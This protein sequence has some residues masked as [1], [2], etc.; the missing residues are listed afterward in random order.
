E[1]DV[2][3]ILSSGIFVFESKNYSGWIFGNDKQKTWTQTLPTGRKNSHKEHFYNPVWQNRT[4]VNVLK[5]YLQTELPIYSVIVF[6]DRC[7]FKNLT[8]SDPDIRVI[9]RK[10]IRDAVAELSKKTDGTISNTDIS[11]LYNKLFLLTQVNEAEKLLHIRQINELLAPKNYTSGTASDSL[12]APEETAAGNSIQKCPLCGS[13]LILRTGKRGAYA[14][15]QFYGCS[16]YPRCRYIR[17]V[18]S[19]GSGSE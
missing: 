16:S 3:L 9:H 2:V 8:V 7:M 11:D 17:N 19:S 12:A 5:A 4:H 18:G 1:L 6:S 10:D 14:G 15:R 13:D